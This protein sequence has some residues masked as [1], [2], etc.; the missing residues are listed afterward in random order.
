MKQTN[1]TYLVENGVLMADQDDCV[2]ISHC[3]VI[4]EPIEQPLEQRV[5]AALVRMDKAASKWMKRVVVCFAL[6]LLYEVCHAF[7]SGA[8]TRLVQ[9]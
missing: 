1:G 8:V 6:Y 9:Q 4:I 2:S 7:A 3:R 5:N